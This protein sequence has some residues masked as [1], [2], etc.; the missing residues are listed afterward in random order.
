MPAEL[1]LAA[2]RVL[3]LPS[4]VDQCDK[5]EQCCWRWLAHAVLKESSWL[6]EDLCQTREEA[7]RAETQRV[8]VTIDSLAFAELRGAHTQMEQELGDLR[9]EAA[10]LRQQLSVVTSNHSTY[11][12]RAQELD[13]A[14]ILAEEERLRALEAEREAI[15]RRD[16]ACRALDR[17][18]GSEDHLQRQ[19]L[20]L[21]DER[22]RAVG[23]L[24]AV[25]RERD[26]LSASVAVKVKA[27][28]KRGKGSPQRFGSSR[29]Q[30]RGS[31]GRRT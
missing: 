20:R 19:L 28:R 5:G 14:L 10:I 21:E 6:R 25:R 31:R 1:G 4:H 29:S 9:C 11:M 8:K 18:T 7:E 13:Q 3:T 2:H 24:Q 26:I 12:A 27:R 22:V 15:I 23:E 17:A 30:S 16:D